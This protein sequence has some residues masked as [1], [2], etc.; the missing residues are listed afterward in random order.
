MRDQ[1]SLVQSKDSRA[2]ETGN[3]DCRNK[4]H[5]SA[6]H[7][8]PGL[9]NARCS[10]Y[11]VSPTT[12]VDQQ[13]PLWSCLDCTCS[14]QSAAALAHGERARIKWHTA[15]WH[16]R[17]VPLGVRAI[18]TRIGGTQRYSMLARTRSLLPPPRRRP[19]SAMKAQKPGGGSEP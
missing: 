13:P 9:K 4:T 2:K 15:G 11:P 12:R 19:T 1:P 6:F 17:L 18:S 16:G 7:F 3:V 5:H 8:A 10:S 14:S